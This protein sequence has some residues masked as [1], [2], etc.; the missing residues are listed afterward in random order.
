MRNL[1]PFEEFS[2]L[3]LLNGAILLG[4]CHDGTS[5]KGFWDFLQALEKDE[6]KTPQ[7]I[8]MGDIFD[9]LVGEIKPTHEFAK[10]YI[11]LLERLCDKMQ[12]IYLEGNHDFNLASLFQKVKII[13][14]QNQPLKL[15]LHTSKGEFAFFSHGDIFL[16][17]FLQFLLKTLRN[18]YLLVFLNCLNFLSFNFLMKMILK[19]QLK[20]NLF[21][22]IENFEILARKR[23]KRYGKIGAWVCEGHY[24][25]NLILDEENMKYINLPSFAYERSFFVVECTDKIKF[26]EQKLRGQNV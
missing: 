14:L 6:I 3:K 5:R 4:D 24:H 23:Y 20:K 17:P 10:P 13:P 15:R 26:Q 11:A 12:I 22:K 2:N 16:A 1:K 8:L 21:F 18:H 25:Q 7:L 19:K 9:V